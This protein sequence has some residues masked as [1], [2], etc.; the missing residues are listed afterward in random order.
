MHSILLVGGLE[1]F[2]FSHILRIATP[3][4][5]HIFQRGRYTTNQSTFI[6]FHHCSSIV[7]L[8]T[9]PCRSPGAA[10][11]RCHMAPYHA[12][13]GMVWC[14]KSHRKSWMLIAIH[15]RQDVL[16]DLSEGL[17]NDQ[18]QASLRDCA[19]PFGFVGKW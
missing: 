3:T 8:Q 1:H 17:Q 5:F 6:I 19:F 15:I 14:P 4:D 2:L 11:Y 18:H 10:T 9:I 16:R 13:H 12:G 7:A